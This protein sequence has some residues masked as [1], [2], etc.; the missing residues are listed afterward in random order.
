MKIDFNRA[1][2]PLLKPAPKKELPTISE[3]KR[4]VD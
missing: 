3:V 4:Y 1:D 2:H